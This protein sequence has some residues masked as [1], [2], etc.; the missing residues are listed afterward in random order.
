MWT[1]D[2]EGGDITLCLVTQSRELEAVCTRFTFPFPYLSI[3]FD[4]TSQ[5]SLVSIFL[6]PT[7]VIYFHII[8]YYCVQSQLLFPVTVLPLQYIHYTI[9]DNFFKHK[10]DPP[11]MIFPTP[12]HIIFP[13]ESCSLVQTH[14][15]FRYINLLLDINASFYHRIFADD[16]FFSLECAPLPSFLPFLYHLDM[17]H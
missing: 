2:C 6:L 15:C 4:F 7:L 8:F 1:Q 9:T 13:I 11:I 3:P 12:C 14:L 17:F 5:T 16:I 10:F